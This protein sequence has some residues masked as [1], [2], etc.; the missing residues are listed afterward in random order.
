VGYRMAVGFCFSV[1]PLL[2]CKIEDRCGHFFSC[3]R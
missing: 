3:A 2:V 1:F